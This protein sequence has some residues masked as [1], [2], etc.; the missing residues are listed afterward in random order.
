MNDRDHRLAERLRDRLELLIKKTAS[1][2]QLSAGYWGVG[3]PAV[4][5]QISDDWSSGRIS[6]RAAWQYAKQGLA[7]I[8][9]DDLDMADLYAWLATDMYVAALEARLSHR[10]A[11]LALLTRPAG[12]RGRP[13]NPK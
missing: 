11:D 4:E 7:A 8:D 6:W 13:K 1:A 12:R 9:R 2:E 3:I 5:R 10:P